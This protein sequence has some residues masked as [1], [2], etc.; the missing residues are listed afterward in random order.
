MQLQE[1]WEKRHIRQSVSPWGAPTMFV[2]KKDGI[3]W[4]CIDH[5]QLSKVNVKEKYPFPRIDDLFYQMRR[6]KVFSKIDLRSGDQQVRIK[7]E[8]VHKTTFRARLII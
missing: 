1:L 6:E 5:R 4:L 2:K 3:V 8:D 7:N